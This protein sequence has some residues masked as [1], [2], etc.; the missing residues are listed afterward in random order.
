MPRAKRSTH[1]LLLAVLLAACGAADLEPTSGAAADE[2]PDD[3]DD[4]GWVW[5][6]GTDPPD[7]GGED[8]RRV[9]VAPGPTDD[10]EIIKN[11]PVARH[12]GDATRRVVL[13]LGPGDLPS[14]QTGDRLV[15]PAE[16]QVTTRCD[17]GQ[18]APGCDYNPNVA[19]Q[20]LLTKAANDT[21]PAGQGSKA[22]S[23]VQSLTCT[24]AEHHCLFTFQRTDTAVTLTDAFDLP[25]VAADACHVNLVM[26]AW[27]PDARAGGVDKVLVGENEGDYLANGTILGDKGR[28]MAVRERDLTAADRPRSETTGGGSE[29]IPTT[30]DPVLVYS[31]RLKPGD[32][33]A[34]EQYLIEAKV[35]VAVGARARVSTRLFV[36]KDPGADEPNGAPAQIFPGAIG[37]H[38]GTNCT[39]GTSPCTLRKAAVFRVS[40]DL[41]GPVHVNLVVTSA[42]PGGGSTKVTVKR[43]DGYLRS[44]RYRAALKG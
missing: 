41:A 33:L 21:D 13:R 16:V 39:P 19:A 26:W 22:L 32:L 8:P 14:L 3:P 28:L 43:G 37:E 4:D 44:T 5:D 17:V 30:A 38:N 7:G 10:A 1:G 6:D 24:Q 9:L 40:D 25:C 31:H 27:H 23:A 11:L 2:A 20:L 42:V 36:T 18:T 34:G 35:V 15:I 29:D 12:E